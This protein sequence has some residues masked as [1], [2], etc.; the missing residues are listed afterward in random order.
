MFS[1][2]GRADPDPKGFAWLATLT[3][4]F[5][6]GY[7]A[8]TGFFVRDVRDRH[9]QASGMQF[10]IADAIRRGRTVCDA[11]AT[12]LFDVDYSA[13]AHRPVEEVRAM[14]GVPPKSEAALES[15][16]CSASD[17][18]G[19]SELQQAYVAKRSEARKRAP[20]LHPDDD[21]PHG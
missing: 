5:E 9:V 19:M 12:D 20:Q 18:A 6:T 3:G 8:D 10:R 16:S 7:I 11:Y 15:G 1:F 21:G 4:L 17:V 14:I 2:I 13:L